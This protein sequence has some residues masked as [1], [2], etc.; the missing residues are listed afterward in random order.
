M[1]TNNLLN[2]ILKAYKHMKYV[3]YGFP[4]EINKNLTMHNV[5]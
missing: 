1:I 3:L 4:T 5:L 2:K